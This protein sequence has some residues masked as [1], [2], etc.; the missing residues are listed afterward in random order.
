MLEN[1]LTLKVL[2]LIARC[3]IALLRAQDGKRVSGTINSLSR[4]ADALDS[5]V[6]LA[7][8]LRP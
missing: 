8:R 4:E 6:R 7:D 1:A 5:E 3:L 2:V